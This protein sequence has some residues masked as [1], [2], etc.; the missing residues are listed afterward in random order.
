MAAVGFLPRAS[1]V[2]DIDEGLGAG[3]EERTMILWGLQLTGW[4]MATLGRITGGLF[5]KGK[6]L[7]MQ[8]GLR[9]TVFWTEMGLRLQAQAGGAGQCS[10]SCIPN[11]VDRIWP[12]FMDRQCFVLGLSFKACYHSK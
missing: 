11:C 3:E 4:F 9:V 1:L 10:T 12:L 6:F 7:L 2:E 5:E 8:K